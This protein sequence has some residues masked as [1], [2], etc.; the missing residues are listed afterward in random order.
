MWGATL[1]SSQGPRYAAHPLSW[2]FDTIC[3][4]GGNQDNSF[5]MG[6]QLR[7]KEVA[8]MRDVPGKPSFST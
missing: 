2:S 5:E 3:E 7:S 4:K 8:A 6:S 1:G